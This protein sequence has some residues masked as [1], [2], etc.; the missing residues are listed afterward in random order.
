MTDG[1]E[2]SSS[3]GIAASLE[4]IEE[5]TKRKQEKKKAERKADPKT[6]MEEAVSSSSSSSSNIQNSASK[7]KESTSRHRQI[8]PEIKITNG[9]APLWQPDNYANWAPP[10]RKAWTRI[11]TDP[12]NFYFNYSPP[13]EKKLT[14]EWSK[15]EKRLFLE[16]LVIYPVMEK[17]WGLFS[18]NIRG[19]TGAQCRKFFLHLQSIGE[20]SKDGKPA[21]DFQYSDVIAMKN[22]GARLSPPRGRS[23]E[24]RRR[25]AKKKKRGEP[26]YLHTE[27]EEEEK[28]TK[29]QRGS[30][31]TKLR[32]ERDEAAVS[33]AAPTTVSSSTPTPLPTS[34]TGLGE[35]RREKKR[36][37]RSSAAPPTAVGVESDVATVEKRGGE[38]PSTKKVALD[39]GSGSP[40]AASRK[41]KSSRVEPK[42]KKVVEQPIRT[43]VSEPS[44]GSVLEDSDEDDSMLGMLA[45]TASADT[46]SKDSVASP[47]EVVESS[48]VKLTRKGNKRQSSIGKKEAAAPPAVY[49]PVGNFAHARVLRRSQLEGYEDEVPRGR[50]EALI[51]TPLEVHQAPQAELSS[52]SAPQLPESKAA[53]LVDNTAY[54]SA[55]RSL[56]FKFQH[57]YQRLR[58][59]CENLMNETRKRFSRTCE[60]IRDGALSTFH[61]GVQALFTRFKGSNKS[62]FR[63]FDRNTNGSL[64]ESLRR[65]HTQY[66]TDKKNMEKLQRMELLSLAGMHIHNLNNL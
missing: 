8:V 10:K 48:K 50:P 19:R 17:K 40:S 43:A 22:G 57:Q 49:L 16:A 18:L 46:T 45:R 4:K 63:A 62:A 66:E 64:S 6:M 37:S 51:P 32:D 11:A 42:K 30:K 15:E 47:T 28:Q 29:T 36:K 26:Q 3:S 33:T 39:V 59:S 27:P 7:K 60:P 35:K 52:F 38:V 1:R 9:K 21:V 13:G 34:P 56:Q 12:E 31:K 65:I 61:G 58:H 25:E 44:S 2:S 41:K 14:S 53:L 23:V 20:V 54:L 24:K 5:K 55:E